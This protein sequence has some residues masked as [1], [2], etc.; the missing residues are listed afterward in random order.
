MS[1]SPQVLE[2]L[3]VRVKGMKPEDKADIIREINQ[4]NR[5]WIPNPGAQT[6]A[7]FSPADVIG[8]GGEAGPGKTSLLV[9]LALHEH[10]R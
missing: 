10:R 5:K 7:Y 8:F 9:G 4:E 6:E 3:I 2:D 1:T